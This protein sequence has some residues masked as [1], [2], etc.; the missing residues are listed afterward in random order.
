MKELKLTGG[1]IALVD[2]DVYALV[3]G[4]KWYHSQLYPMSFPRIR[5]HNIV[6]LY[7]TCPSKLKKLL[8]NANKYFIDI[9]SRPP[10]GYVIDHINGNPLD[11]RAVNLRLCTIRENHLNSR[12]SITNT[13]GFKGVSKRKNRYVAQITSMGRR[14]YLGMYKLPEEAAKAYNQAAIRHFGEFARLNDVK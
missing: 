8:K 2:D 10:V 5:L 12:I 6:Y 9:H 14:V 3:S 1:Q 7:S 4:F 13:T 11:N